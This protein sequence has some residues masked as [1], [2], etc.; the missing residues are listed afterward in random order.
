VQLLTQGLAL[1]WVAGLLAQQPQPDLIV[2]LDGGRARLAR[3]E[4]IRQQV[5]SQSPG[6][7]P[8]WLLIRCPRGQVPPRPLP[9]L[10]EG[11]DTFTQIQ[12]LAAWLQQPGT[13]SPQRLW[14]ATDPSHTPRA[15]LLAQLAL[16][17]RGIR[18]LP[19]DPPTPPQREQAKLWRDGLRFALWRST[20]LGAEQLAAVEVQRKRQACGL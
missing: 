1:V 11:Y 6:Q 15:V 20:G 16:V 2:V 14:I 18:V 3:A 12:A 9:E 17:G 13:P 4:A 5:L 7:E 8:E 19:V 10:L